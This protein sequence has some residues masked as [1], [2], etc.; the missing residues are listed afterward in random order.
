MHV[1]GQEDEN[2]PS[3]V[4]SEGLDKVIKVISEKSMFGVPG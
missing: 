4:Y 1:W 3:S 2:L